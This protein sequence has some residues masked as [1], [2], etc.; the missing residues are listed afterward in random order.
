MP[1]LEPVHR[2]GV[3]AL[4]ILVSAHYFAEVARTPPS[5]DA[6]VNLRN[7]K[8]V[9]LL[10]NDIVLRLVKYRDDDNRNWSFREVAK[11]LS[12]RKA[13]AARATEASAAIAK[14]VQRTKRLEDFR[15]RAIAHLTKQGPVGVSLP[16]DVTDAIRLAL[17]IVDTLS[18]ERNQYTLGAI[19]LREVVLGPADAGSGRSLR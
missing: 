5:D 6:D 11:Y 19:S 4:E 10:L 14:F 12:K 7:I 13:Y 3:E 15:N 2:L 1:T 17:D 16:P 8:F 18:G 9:Q